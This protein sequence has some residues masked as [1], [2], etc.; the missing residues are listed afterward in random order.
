LKEVITEQS[1]IPKEQRKLNR[2]K[3]L[4][5]GRKVRRASSDQK[6]IAIESDRVP[7]PVKKPR[8]ENRAFIQKKK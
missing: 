2:I 5:W 6:T 4:Y 7:S 8:G 1:I 3:R